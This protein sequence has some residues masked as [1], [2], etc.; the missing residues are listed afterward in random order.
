MQAHFHLLVSPT[1]R[2]SEFIRTTVSWQSSHF[3]LCL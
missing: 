2:L 1:N 3:S